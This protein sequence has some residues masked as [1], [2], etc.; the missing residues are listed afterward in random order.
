MSEVAKV[1]LE[2]MI[3]DFSNNAEVTP[4]L[5]TERRDRILQL[6]AAM[7]QIPESYNM[8]QFNPGKIKHHFGS[9]VYG[10]E[11]F[12]P[13]G[14]VIVSKIHRGKTLNVIAQGRISVID[15]E[16]G[17]NT[18]EAPYVFVSSP[19]TKRIV[20]AH[21]DTLWI[22]SHANPNDVEDLLE[23]ENITIAKNFED[24]LI[25]GS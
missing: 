18:Y 12:I 5:L 20:I 19:M 3:A 21:E 13:A 8:E 23:V 6:E 25:T 15:P 11:L 9:G 17:F 10:R 22:T 24:K 16:K 14:N 1:E 2:K 4:V 7:I